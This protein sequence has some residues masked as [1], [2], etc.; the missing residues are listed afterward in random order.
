[1]PRALIFVALIAS[2]SLA[3]CGGGGAG[4]SSSL[5]SSGSGGS[6]SSVPVNT[7]QVVSILGS[8]GLT[9]TG[10]ATLYVF[11]GDS[12][13]V[14]NCTSSTC[15]GAWPPYTAPAGTAAPSGSSFGLLKR[16]DSSLQWTLNAVPLYTFSGDTVNG[17]ANGQGLSEFGG[18]WSV[19]RPASSSGGGSSGGNG[20]GY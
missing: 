19:A 17:Q 12:A 15:V 5:P 11:S 10:G 7:P 18:I 3:A 2:T 14:S 20:G 9:T 8:S 13:N 4:S 6:V 16:G 1:M